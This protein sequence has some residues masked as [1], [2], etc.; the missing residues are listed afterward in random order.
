MQ[1]T[2][3]IRGL[4]LLLALVIMV[5][6]LL[7]TGTIAFAEGDDELAVVTEES[8]SNIARGDEVDSLSVEETTT[9]P[10]SETTTKPAEPASNYTGIAYYTY[11]GET[12]WWRFENGKVKPK[13][14][15]VF[16]NEYGWWYVNEG[17][18]DFSHTG[19]DKNQYGWWRIENGKVNFNANGV[20]QNQYGWWYVEN[21]KVNFDYTGVA[22]N[23]YGWWRIENGKVNF[24]FN[25]LAKN[26]YG[27][28]YLQ[29]GKVQFGYTGLA[30]NSQGRWYVENGKV[31]FNY[32]GE[33]DYKG[34]TYTCT[35]GKVTGGTNSAETNAVKVLNS[36]GWDFKKAYYWTI[37]NITY[38]K[39]VVPTDGSYGIMNYANHGF[40]QKSGNCYTFGCCVYYLGRMANEDIHIIKGTVPYAAGGRGAHCWNEVTRNGT[41]YVLDAQYE[42]QWR[43]KGTNP[44][45][46][47]LF[48]YGTKGS[49]VYKAEARMD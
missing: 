27:W 12:A 47:W 31:N 40:V 3:T 23:D 14:S 10:A 8:E 21:G 45:S 49:L 1:D 29:K 30:Q 33:A 7:P 28:W 20:Y 15:G 42:Q 19:I 24:N 43:K 39:T 35:N 36:V 4:S 6:M 34:I 13:A 5:A 22:R 48:T 38:N 16:K 46:G 32:N 17:R 44:Y 37:N 41:T 9:K 25:G 2:K 26:E 11:K 18:V